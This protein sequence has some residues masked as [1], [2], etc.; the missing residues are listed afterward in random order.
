M[1]VCVDDPTV[2]PYFEYRNALWTQLITMTT[3]GYGDISPVTDGGKFVEAVSAVLGIV[4]ISLLVTITQN[5][6]GLS[7]PE[8][9]V[10]PSPLRVLVPCYLV[11]LLIS[12]R[13]SSCVSFALPSRYHHTVL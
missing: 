3:V 1:G 2:C 4:L 9:R 8:A 13:V 12:P 6:T 5:I 11:S 10:L 7:P